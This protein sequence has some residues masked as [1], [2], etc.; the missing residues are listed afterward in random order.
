MTKASENVRLPGRTKPALAHRVADSQTDRRAN[1][2]AWTVSGTKK[3]TGRRT[4]VQK[5][6][7]AGGHS[8]GSRGFPMKGSY[9]K[10]KPCERKAA[11]LSHE[12]KCYSPPCWVAQFSDSRGRSSGTGSPRPPSSQMAKEG[13]RET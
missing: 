10:P 12:A 3:H 9:D 13:G 5:N 4:D 7:Q 8:Q 6:T 2:Q 1:R 11:S